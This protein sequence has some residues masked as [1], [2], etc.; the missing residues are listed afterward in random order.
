VWSARHW[1][2]AQALSLRVEM[3]MI[4]LLPFPRKHF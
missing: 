1:V 4:D 3:A 2:R